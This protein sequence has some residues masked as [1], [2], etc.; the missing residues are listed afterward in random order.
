MV[1]PME[2][3]VLSALAGTLFSVTDKNLGTIVLI[4][5]KSGS[6]NLISDGGASTFVIKELGALIGSPGVDSLTLLVEVDKQFLDLL[7][8]IVE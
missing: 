8:L 2:L 5:V 3:V 7:L 1:R 4:V 6:L